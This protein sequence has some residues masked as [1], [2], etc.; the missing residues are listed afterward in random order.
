MFK[1]KMTLDEFRKTAGHI[2][3]DEA[4]FAQGL[5]DCF[6]DKKAKEP[7]ETSWAHAALIML[8]YISG[9]RAERERRRKK[10][11]TA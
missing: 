6:M 9:I 10:A 4:M 7:A 5:F 2:E 1:V 3:L 8:G 11:A